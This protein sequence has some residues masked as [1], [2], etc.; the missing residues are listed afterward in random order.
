MQILHALTAWAHQ[1][2]D[3]LYQSSEQME[4]DLAEEQEAADA[5]EQARIIAGHQRFCRLL[6]LTP[7]RELETEGDSAPG[8]KGGLTAASLDRSEYSIDA[9]PGPWSV[10]SSH[11]SMSRN[12]SDGSSSSSYH[13]DEQAY[14]Q[15][16]T[17]SNQRVD[18]ALPSGYQGKYDRGADAPPPDTHC[19]FDSYCNNI[20]PINSSNSKQCTGRADYRSDST[21][22][23]QHDQ[24]SRRHHRKRLQELWDQENPRVGPIHTVPQW[25]ILR[26]PSS[27]ITQESLIKEQIHT[28]FHYL[29]KHPEFQRPAD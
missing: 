5:Q 24:N 20:F 28:G 3:F 2:A 6:G 21:F 7:D 8:Y 10:W 9:A 16:Q 29:G 22:R 19:L 13:W 18:M 15:L 1:L 4:L 17:S 26:V 25:H 14:H 23:W 27:G 11:S 12:S